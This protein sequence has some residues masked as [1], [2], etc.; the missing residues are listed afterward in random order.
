[1]KVKLISLGRY[2]HLPKYIN[3]YM[4]NYKKNSGAYHSRPKK[5]M[6]RSHRAF[7]S[8]ALSPNKAA[9]T[10]LLHWCIGGRS[11]LRCFWS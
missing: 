6:N 3:I 9:K 1:M 4:I 8:S 7:H 11:G 2:L 5:G 10:L